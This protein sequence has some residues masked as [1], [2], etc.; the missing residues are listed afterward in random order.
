MYKA[1]FT[2]MDGTLLRDDHSISEATKELIQKLVAAGIPVILVSARPIHGILPISRWLGI[3]TLPV[4]SLNG[5]YIGHEDKVIFESG[6]ELDRVNGLQNVSERYEVTLI[7][8][9]GLEWF[10]ERGNAATTKEQRI[11]SVEV[12]IAP[13]QEL[14]AYWKENDT[15]I[16]KIMAVGEPDVINALQDELHGIYGDGMNIYTSKPTYLE[17][18]RRE[19]SK[20]NAVKFLINRYQF[21]PDEI[22][23]IGDNYND[24]DMIAF[25]GTGIAMGNAP[26]PVKAVAKWVTDTNQNDGVRKAFEKFIEV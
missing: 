10:A 13:F 14:M 12:Q 8:Y 9:A 26:D 1:V 17:I 20:T 5:G 18:M 7:Y 24:K 16:D 22:I 25:A 6:I 3:D 21:T 2:D 15:K 11:T 23:A 4:V 19:A